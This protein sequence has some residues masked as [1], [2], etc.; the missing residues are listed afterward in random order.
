M[1]VDIKR[2]KRDSRK[3]T[4]LQFKEKEP[5]NDN[6][7]SGRKIM[8]AYEKMAV[9]GGREERGRGVHGKRNGM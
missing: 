2:K 7:G 1:R 3:K 9:V 8:G 6:F 4:K 5:E